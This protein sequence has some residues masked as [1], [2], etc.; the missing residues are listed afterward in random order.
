MLPTTFAL[1]QVQDHAW[2]LQSLQPPRHMPAASTHASMASAEHLVNAEVVPAI[3]QAG[4]NLA[5][6]VR[7]R[8]HTHRLHHLLAHLQAERE[9]HVE[10]QEAER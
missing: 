4:S 5:Y 7:H 10:V 2:E 1:E 9:R 6:R 8:H 3:M